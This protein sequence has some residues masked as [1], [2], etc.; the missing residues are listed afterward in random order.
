M[1]ITLPLGRVSQAITAYGRFFF[2]LQVKA[3]F[4]CQSLTRGSII[5]FCW[6]LRFPGFF[7]SCEVSGVLCSH[8]F[9]QSVYGSE[10]HHLLNQTGLL[11]INIESHFFYLFV[12][13]VYDHHR[14]LIVSFFLAKCTP[15]VKQ[16][17]KTKGNSKT[18]HVLRVK[19]SEGNYHVTVM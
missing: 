13:F 1:G 17:V 15:S 8:S 3:G 2:F 14:T 7:A 16:K 5:H 6:Q 10:F 4:P 19:I 12:A 11:L 9:S 18:C